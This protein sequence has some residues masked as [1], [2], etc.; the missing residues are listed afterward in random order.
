MK[1]I[2]I[3]FLLVLLSSLI[4]CAFRIYKIYK[5]EKDAAYI[6]EELIELID[7]PEIPPE[8]PSF[9]V[10]F[11]ELKNINPDVVGWIVVEGTQINYPIVQGKNNSFYLNHSYDK[12]WS[13]FGSV[14]M[15]YKSSSDFTDYNTFI[16]GHHTKDGSM[17]GELYKYLDEGFY[18]AQ[19]FFYLYTPTKNYRVEVFSAY[20]NKSDSDS[21]KDKFSSIEDFQKYLNY[22][23]DKSNYKTNTNVDVNKDKIITLYSCSR[24][25]NWA[26]NDRYFIHGILKS[27]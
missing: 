9:S 12:K 20:V 10:D 18:N 3:L 24:E 21:Y 19:P 11:T 23:I 16:Y 2:K 14:F 25:G 22:I 26:K 6:K 27:I 1:K 7:I 8:E 4:Y 15:D 5:E 17:F 13:G